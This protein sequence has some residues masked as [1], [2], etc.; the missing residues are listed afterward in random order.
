MKNFL[1]LFLII[2]SAVFSC[3]GIKIETKDAS[4]V[5]GRTAEFSV[6]LDIQPLFVPRKYSFTASTPKGDGFT[7]QA[8]YAAIGV[9]TFKD[10]LIIDGFNEKGL[11]IGAFY[12]P[13]YASYS[14]CNDDN[15]M[16]GLSPVD[17]PNWILTQFSSIEEVK[18]ALNDIMIFP[19]FLKNWGGIA[20]PFHY[21]VYDKFG[22]SIVIEPINGSLVIYDNPLGVMTN[23]PT[24]DWHMTNLNN[25]VHISTFNAGSVNIEGITF[26]PFGQGTG[27]LGLPGDFSPPSRFVRA[28]VFSTSVDKV[29]TN[30][31]AVFQAFHVLNQ[32][33]IPIGSVKSQENGVIYSEL[34]EATCVRDVKNLK[35][36][37]KTYNDQTIKM[38]D[39]RKFNYNDKKLMQYHDLDHQQIIEVTKKMFP[40]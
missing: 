6:Q 14:A 1:I 36:Y 40:L 32:F 37:Y 27:L 30:E 23:S 28:V 21:V 3:T 16:K 10:N 25:Y 4:F 39:F 19:T 38:I 9:M 7:Y 33:D 15:Y 20:P 12:F 18:L 24:F 35:F 22:K 11:A 5:T 17:F 13:N 26:K 31:L 34:T 2:Y 8:K 29:A